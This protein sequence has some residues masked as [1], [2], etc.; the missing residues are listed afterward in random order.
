MSKA[1]TA[2]NMGKLPLANGKSADWRND[3]A[4]KLLSSQREDGSWVNPNSRWW[5]NDPQLVTAFSILSLRQIHRAMHT[6]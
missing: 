4:T 2:A 3:L 6:P 1:L 5:E